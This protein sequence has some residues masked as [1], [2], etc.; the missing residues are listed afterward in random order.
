MEKQRILNILPGRLDI[1]DDGAFA[2][3]SELAIVDGVVAY[4]SDAASHAYAA[5]FK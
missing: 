1:D 3:H 5:L 4:A 2:S